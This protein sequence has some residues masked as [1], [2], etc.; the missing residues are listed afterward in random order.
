MR[1]VFVSFTTQDNEKLFQLID[2]K[3]KVAIKV[4]ATG[5][6]TK[7]NQAFEAAGEKWE[8]LDEPAAGRPPT[9]SN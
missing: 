4:E 7:Q 9:A 6:S 8:S 5:T 3:G 2:S 1:R